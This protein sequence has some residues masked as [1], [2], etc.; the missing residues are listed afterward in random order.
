MKKTKIN[1]KY[2]GFAI[3]VVLV[4]I[5]G[6]LVGSTTAQTGNMQSHPASEIA[7]GTFPAGDY[8]FQSWSKIFGEGRFDIWADS[9]LNLG[10]KGDGAIRMR[11]D[12]D[13]NHGSSFFTVNSGAS[14][15]NNPPIK[16][17]FTI[18]SKGLIT[19]NGARFFLLGKDGAN[20]FWFMDGATEG[21]NNVLGI[22]AVEHSVNIPKL[23]VDGSNV[24]KSYL[25]RCYS[26]SVKDHIYYV[27]EAEDQ[28]CEGSGAYKFERSYKIVT[29]E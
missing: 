5:M 18:D 6:F 26:D 29:W 19:S 13:G 17:L 27:T 2:F 4:G 10:T 24:K 21:T 9:D 16:D 8:R 12:T 7:P 15:P 3:A 28:S 20:T 11:L 25:N 14:V 22:N 1:K 23:K